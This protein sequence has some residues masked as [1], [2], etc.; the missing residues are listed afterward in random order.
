MVD[1]KRGSDFR[2]AA[3]RQKRLKCKAY[4]EK[5]SSVL[6]RLTLRHP[7]SRT[8]GTGTYAAIYG[9]NTQPYFQSFTHT[10]MQY[11]ERVVN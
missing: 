10:S 7:N 6:S 3:D 1:L 9:A 11:I 2:R 4:R 8:H 5:L